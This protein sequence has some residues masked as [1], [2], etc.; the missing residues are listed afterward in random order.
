MKKKIFILMIVL[1][2][3]LIGLVTAVSLVMNLNISPENKEVLKTKVGEGIGEINKTREIC[4]NDVCIN[5]TYTDTLK[6]LED[7]CDGS[8][9]YF[10]SYQDGGINKE[11]KVKLERICAKEGICKDEEMEYDCCLEWREE[12]DEEILNKANKESENILN[13]IASVTLE[14]EARNKVKRFDDI[15]IT[16]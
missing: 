7:G 6:L 9:C 10:T 16:I 1:M 4:E 13:N 2:I 12:T 3:C 5:E 11:F 15:N 8:Y 14:R